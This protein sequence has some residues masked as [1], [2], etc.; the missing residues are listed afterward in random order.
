MRLLM[1]GAAAVVALGFA[2]ELRA[3]AD[4]RHCPAVTAGGDV[5][6]VC[7]FPIT[8]LLLPPRHDHDSYRVE[9]VLAPGEIYRLWPD[10]SFIVLRRATPE[11]LRPA[12]SPASPN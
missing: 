11:D 9:R 10:W 2:S 4:L 1:M 8:I 7:D 6:N 3:Q 5:R 12:P